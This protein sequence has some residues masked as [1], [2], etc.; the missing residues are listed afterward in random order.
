MEGEFSLPPDSVGPRLLSVGQTL[1]P[2]LG[3]EE[4]VSGTGELFRHVLR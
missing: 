4:T 2:E 3:E 1:Q